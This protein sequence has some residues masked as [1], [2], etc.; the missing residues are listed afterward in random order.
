MNKINLK[1]YWIDLLISGTI[2]KLSFLGFAFTYNPVAFFIAGISLYRIGAFIH[3]IAHQNTNKEFTSFKRFWN[4]FIGPLVLTPSILF[5]RPHLKH[6]TTGVFSTKDDP[7]YPLIKSNKRLA[8]VVFCILPFLLPI[9]NLCVCVFSFMEDRNPFLSILYK[10]VKFSK[11]DYIEAKHYSFWYLI[12][13]EVLVLWLG[14]I[15]LPL[16]F[17]SVFAWFLST[18]RI[19]LEHELY[20]YKE[21]SDYNDQKLDSKTHRHWLYIIIQP[22]A[23]RYHTV[24]HMY[25]RIPYHNLEKA[26]KELNTI[27]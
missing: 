23:L 3:E 15:I 1:T 8:F 7:Q 13:L 4:I 20:F 26:D 14:Y 25:P 9:Y 24:H 6:H 19:P 11:E 12:V 18:L 5:V 17:V 16:Y 10:G 21:T 22:L 27:D 2:F